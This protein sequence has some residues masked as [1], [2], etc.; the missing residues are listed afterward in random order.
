MRVFHT[1]PSRLFNRARECYPLSAANSLGW[2]IV[3]AALSCAKF[4]ILNQRNGPLHHYRRVEG[5]LASAAAIR[6]VISSVMR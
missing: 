3:G 1:P 4:T 5:L 6:Y 2:S